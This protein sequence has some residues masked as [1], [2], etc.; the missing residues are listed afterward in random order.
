MKSKYGFALSEVGTLKSRCPAGDL[1]AAHLS[2]RSQ[3]AEVAFQVSMSHQFHHYQC[4]LALGHHPKEA[5]LQNK[6]GGDSKR[7]QELFQLTMDSLSGA[8]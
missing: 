2:I 4:W 8:H 7:V 5:D 3:R 1:E 6:H